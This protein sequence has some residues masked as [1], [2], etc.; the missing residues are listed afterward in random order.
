MEGEER[1]EELDIVEKS[2]DSEL[3]FLFPCLFEL[4][5]LTF[6]TCV[7]SMD[8]MLLRVLRVL[9]GAAWCWVLWYSVVTFSFHQDQLNVNLWTI[10]KT[11]DKER[12]T[13][14]W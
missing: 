4:L 14:S 7:L 5:P 11:R 10:E 13:T 12:S 3:N 6:D 2:S 1:G 8:V 9:R